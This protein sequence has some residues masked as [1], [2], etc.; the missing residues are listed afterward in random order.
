MEFMES[1]IQCLLGVHNNDTE[2]L[3]LK[4]KLNGSNSTFQCV[5]S[6]GY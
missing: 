6:H 1:F 2:T 5:Y 4:V 3:E